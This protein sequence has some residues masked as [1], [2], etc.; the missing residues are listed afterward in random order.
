MFLFYSCDFVNCQLDCLGDAWGANVPVEITSLH[1]HSLKTSTC[2]FMVGSQFFF[3]HGIFSRC[4]LWFQGGFSNSTSSFWSTL[5][6][7]LLSPP[8]NTTIKSP[9][10]VHHH[11]LPD[12]YDPPTLTVSP[13]CH[14]WEWSRAPDTTAPCHGRSLPLGRGSHVTFSTQMPQGGPVL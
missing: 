9:A 14:C 3:W 12:S 6:F 5:C 11:L 1:W 8:I 2:I 7:D 4:Y 13:G 10:G